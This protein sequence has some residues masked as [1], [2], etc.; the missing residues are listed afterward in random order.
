MAF[1]GHINGRGQVF[2]ILISHSEYKIFN[3]TPVASCMSFIA[4][5]FADVFIPDI[6]FAC[7]EIRKRE[8]FHIP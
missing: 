3:D 1:D 6:L 8:G 7:K 2:L 4:G 5:Q